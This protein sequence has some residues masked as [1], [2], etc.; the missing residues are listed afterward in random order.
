MVQLVMKYHSVYPFRF[1]VLTITVLIGIGSCNSEWRDPPTVSQEDFLS[2]HEDWRS[3]R[4][5]AL[6]TPPSGPVLWS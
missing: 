3:N 4:E 6:V 5:Q 2:E 1:N